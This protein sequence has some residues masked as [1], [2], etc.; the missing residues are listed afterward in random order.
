MRSYIAS[1]RLTLFHRLITSPR[2]R[3]R[4][5]AKPL[6]LRARRWSGRTGSRQTQTVDEPRGWAA[7]SANGPARVRSRWDRRRVAVTRHVRSAHSGGNNPTTRLHL[8]PCRGL[9]RRGLAHN[10]PREAGP[11]GHRTK[12]CASGRVV[13]RVEGLAGGA[14]I[15]AVVSAAEAVAGRKVGPSGRVGRDRRSETRTGGIHPLRP[16]MGRPRTA[17]GRA[18]TQGR[19]RTNPRDVSG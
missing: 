8:P 9:L 18:V 13:G 7:G 6:G 11:T 19:G 10:L 5:V 15:A 14:G 16:V 4:T 12:G 3:Q 17:G 1:R 2:G